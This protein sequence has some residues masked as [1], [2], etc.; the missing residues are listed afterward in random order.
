MESK[1]RGGGGGGGGGG[2]FGVRGGADVEDDLVVDVEAD[3]DEEVEARR[4]SGQWARAGRMDRRRAAMFILR[5]LG[6]GA[7]RWM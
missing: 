5:D 2:R 1:C 7:Q 3:V 6:L 4:I